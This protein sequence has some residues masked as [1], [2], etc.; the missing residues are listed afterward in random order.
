[1]CGI[2]GII[3]FADNH[4]AVESLQKMQ[5]ALYSRGP[6]NSG[7][8]YN[9]PV[10]FSHNRL[11]IIDLSAQGHQPMLSHDARFS[12]TYNGEIYN[13]L[14]LRAECLRLGS[15]FFSHTDTEVI[16]ECYRHFGVAM[17]EKF[18]GMWA[19]ALYDIEKNEI[20]FSRDPFGIKPLYYGFLNGAFYFASEPKALRAASKV[21]SIPDE[22]SIT[23]FIEHAYLDRGA[24]TFFEK[25]KRFPHAS[26][27]VISL[28]SPK[29][30]IKPH[31]YWRPPTTLSKI[32]YNDA[33]VELQRLL[34]NSIKL[35]LRGDVPIG[36]CLSGGIDSSA[37][38]SIA[39]KE[40]K[41]RFKTFTVFYSKHEQVNE[42]K[43]AE[44]IIQH[45]QSNGIFVEP[46]FEAFMEDFNAL[47]Y[48]QDEPFGTTSI[49]AQYAIFKRI[50]AEKIKVILDGQGA[51]E[52]LSGY[53]GFIPIYL[54]SLLKN[55]QYLQFFQENRLLKKNY[56]TAFSM[57]VAFQHIIKKIKES[58]IIVNSVPQIK[59]SEVADTLEDRL[60][61]LTYQPTQYEEIL[62]MLVTE[63]NIPQLLR[64]EDRNSM[65]FS[66]ESR[67]PFLE[68]ELVNFIL[69]LPA[70]FKIKNGF[71]KAILREALKGVVPEEVRLRTSKLGFPTPEI[72]W[73]KQGFNINATMAGNKSWRELVTNKW[74]K[75]MAENI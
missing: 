29:L 20:I 50:A 13:Y 15:K 3:T 60:R 42:R 72:E 9:H 43:W 8:W 55:K 21:F 57:K 36:A 33:V 38:V 39:S 12:I 61:F 73:L 44:K 69:S 22:I 53:I 74:R 24:W 65:A 6:D 66:I 31:S 67:V 52:Q 63:S 54:S 64:Y 41:Q 56:N 35:H 51:D 62:N 18:K 14:E 47:I 40:H 49:Y 59:L 68:L 70:H 25:I 32:N 5:K 23:L 37:I 28:N 30:V 4:G 48:A 2:A 16:I 46:T 75:I 11:S 7:I 34:S 10:Y 27:A 71:T 19:F 58:Q 45:T 1:M 17:F 26:Y